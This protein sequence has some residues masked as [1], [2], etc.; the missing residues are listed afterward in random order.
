MGCIVGYS[1]GVAPNPTYH[2]IQD[3][4]EALWIEYHPD[5]I[6]YTELLEEVLDYPFYPQTTQYRSA[7]FP[8]SSQQQDEARAFV[9]QLQQSHADKKVYVDVEPATGTAFY[10]AEDYH[11]HFLAKQQSSRTLKPW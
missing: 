5:R 1:G 6:S 7:I 8:L 4:T 2:N 3:Y 10:R 9:D 11:Q